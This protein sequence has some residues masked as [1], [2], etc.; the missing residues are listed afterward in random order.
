[1]TT[2]FYE[3]PIKKG[4]LVECILS[5]TLGITVRGRVKTAIYRRPKIWITPLRINNKRLS[6]ENRTDLCIHK[7]AITKIIM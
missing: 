6:P 5:K 3:I 1:M 4:Q 2:N 7:R